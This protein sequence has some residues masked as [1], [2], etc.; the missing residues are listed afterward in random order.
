M[1]FGAQFVNYFTTWEETLS[2]IKVVETGRWHSL[3][4]SD[5]FLPPI[6][7]AGLDSGAALESWSMITATA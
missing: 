1:Q 7:G 6:P 2:A 5:H 3:W 4:F